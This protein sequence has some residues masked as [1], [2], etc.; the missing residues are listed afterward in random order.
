MR[1]FADVAI[2]PARPADID[3]IREVNRAA[4]GSDDEIN[5]V[6]RLRGDGD[7]IVELVADLHG[8]LVGHLMFSRLAIARAD[9]SA[10]AAAALAPV[11]IRPSHQRRGFGSAL[12]RQGI[13][14]CR[15]RQIA[16]VL[17]LGH[18]DYYPRF[19]FSA[20]AA[21]GLVAPFSG[22]AFMALE[23]TPGAL[24]GARDVHYAAAFG[25]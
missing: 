13:E 18:P 16:A 4:F 11:A 5:L 23:L 24:A 3:L 19:G 10:V 12:I 1:Q 6:D 15:A 22:P 17:V 2:R 9:G 8:D 21:R 25:L 14:A 20:D 7:G